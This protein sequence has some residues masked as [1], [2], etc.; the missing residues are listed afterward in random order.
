MKRVCV[1]EQHGGDGYNRVLLRRESS[2]CCLKD[3][4]GSARRTFVKKLI[5]SIADFF[6]S[7][8]FSYV[9]AKNGVRNS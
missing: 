3:A 8:D 5:Q 2:N 9:V 7:G 4:I 6:A 1:Q